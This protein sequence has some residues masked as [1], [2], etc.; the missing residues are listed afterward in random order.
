MNP[1][2]NG[3]CG[4]WANQNFG[5]Y[6]VS[7]TYDPKRAQRL[8][9]PGDTAGISVLAS[10]SRSRRARRWRSRTS[11][12]AGATRR[13]PTTAPSAAADFDK[14]NLTAPL[15]S[16]PAERRRLRVEGIYDVKPAKFGLVDNYVTFAKNFGQG[17]IETFNGVDINLNARLRGGLTAQGR[18]QHRAERT[19][20]LRR[21]GAAS[22]NR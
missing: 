17:R 19:E 12:G 2:A 18:R 4:A 9:R 21:C 22:G 20:R 10:S 8:E 11:G 1:A 3:E 6:V 7:T 5:K 16:A 13:S 15:D 14:F